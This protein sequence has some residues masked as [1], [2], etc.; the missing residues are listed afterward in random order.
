MARIEGLADAMAANVLKSPYLADTQ[1]TALAAPVRDIRN[2]SALSTAQK[3]PYSAPA[4]RAL[5]W[6]IILKANSLPNPGVATDWATITPGTAA[7]F[8]LSPTST[9]AGAIDASGRD[10]EPLNIFSQ[11]A[12]LKEGKSGSETVDLSAIFTDSV[13]G[14]V[15]APYGIT[16]PRPT[17]GPY[18][19]FVT[20][21]GMDPTGQLP[22]VVLSM[23]KA[24]QVNGAYPNLSQDEVFYAKFG[25][26]A[27]K[28]CV[29][30][31]AITP[32]LAA[33]AQIDVDLPNMARTFSF[34]GSG[35]A[36]PT[37]VIPV[38][39]TAPVLHPVRIHLKSPSA[40]QPD[41][42]V[43]LTLTPAS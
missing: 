33:G 34:T 37:I 16:S 11:L 28:R 1:G 31:A 14:A 43:T 5:G 7:R 19:S 13:L 9:T 23:A 10:L 38:T 12:R 21:W 40:V 22:P 32:A 25:L 2:I 41:V 26:N 18:A 3:T 4:I 29:L 15:T 8:F 6:D 35:G 42:L 20:D 24:T 39:A 27:D 36:T 30:S 17:T